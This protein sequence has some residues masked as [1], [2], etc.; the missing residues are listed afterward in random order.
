MTRIAV[1]ALF[2]A[3]L[4]SAA[5]PAPIRISTP[6]APPEWALLERALVEENARWMDAFAAKYVNP[7]N[8]YLEIVEH[9]GGADGPDDAMENFW[10]WPMLYTLGGPR[11]SLDLFHRIWEGHIRQYTKL[12]MYHR[13]YMTAFD[14]EHNGEGYEAFLLLPLADPAGP[15]TRERIVRFANFY[16]GRDPKAPNYDPQHKIIRSIL[17]GSRGARLEATPEYW[18][19]YGDGH[20][21]RDSGNWTQ[22]KGD[23]PMNLMATSLAVNAYILTGDPHYR[24]WVLEYIGAWRDRARANHG[25]V[26]SIVGLNGVVGEGWN[27]KWYG[28]LMGWDWTFGGWPILSRGVR[29]GFRNAAAL[30]GAGFIE[31]LRAQG[32]RLFENRIKTARGELFP[33]KYGDKGPYAPGDGAFYEGLFSDIYLHTLDRRDL[34]TLYRASA[35]RPEARRNRPAWDFEYEAG[36]YEGGNEVAWIDFLEGRDPGY[37]AR[38]LSGSMARIRFNMEAIAADTSTPDTRQADTMHVLRASKAAPLGAVGAVTGALVNLTLGAANPLWCGGLLQAEVRYFDPA[39]RRP[40]LPEDVAALVTRIAPDHVKL[41]LVNVSQTVPRTVVVQTG[42]YGEHEAERVET[43]GKVTP[44][45]DRA[46]RVELAPGAGGEITVYRKRFARRP[47]FD[48]P[49]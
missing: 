41:T 26:P 48:L 42:G 15:R 4:A 38:A 7:D 13:E 11:R 1:C 22:V 35:P 29:I 18:G 47:S 36:R 6:M 12:G 8:G 24:D 17:N 30:G 5:G 2:C 49:M 33:G 16:T 45:A 44:V 43:G 3:S 9:W 46:F 28:G 10:N 21:F 34:E 37:P 14:W 25:W 27:G 32:D 31:A 39:A 23:V 20:Y 19:D 40:G